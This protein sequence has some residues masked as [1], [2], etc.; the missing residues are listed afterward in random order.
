MTK[1]EQEDYNK[2]VKEVLEAR[3]QRLIKEGW[4]DPTFNVLQKEEDK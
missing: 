3:K 2:K 1:K 4:V